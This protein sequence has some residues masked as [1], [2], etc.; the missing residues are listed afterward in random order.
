MD[1][2]VKSATYESHVI[3]HEAVEDWWIGRV[4]DSDGQL[5]LC[6]IITP[7]CI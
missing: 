6:L 2:S 5:G 4:S 3:R 1:G 7:S